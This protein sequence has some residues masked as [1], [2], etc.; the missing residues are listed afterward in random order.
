MHIV[1]LSVLHIHVYIINKL[2]VFISDYMYKK[3]YV[4]SKEETSIPLTHI[5]SHVL[6]THGQLL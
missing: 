4:N 2:I 1:Y 6:C 3:I 5:L